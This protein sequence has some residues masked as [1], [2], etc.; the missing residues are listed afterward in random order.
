MSAEFNKDW[1]KDPLAQAVERIAQEQ[2]KQ[3]RHIPDGK[4]MTQAMFAKLAAKQRAE[5]ERII[6]ALVQKL[7]AANDWDKFYGDPRFLHISIRADELAKSCDI[8]QYSMAEKLSHPHLLDSMFEANWQVVYRTGFY[9]DFTKY[10]PEHN[11]VMLIP[12]G[13]KHW[14]DFQKQVAIWHA[15]K[16]GNFSHPEW[17]I[18]GAEF[19]R[20]EAWRRAKT[21]PWDDWRGGLRDALVGDIE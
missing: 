15:P 1:N 8:Y 16:G 12:V 11:Y 20:D 21:M 19:I 7:E 4:K 14:P 2:I 9:A 5:S 17:V 6:A 10:R 18:F 13:D 3:K